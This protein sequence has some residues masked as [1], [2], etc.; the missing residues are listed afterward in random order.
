M[1]DVIW[2]G[3]GLFVYL[4]PISVAYVRQPPNVW[5][6][7]VVNLFLGW[8]IIGWVVAMAM[9]VRDVPESADWD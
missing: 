3:F 9:A 4:A 8:T 6:I 7:A 5:S 2:F 1:V